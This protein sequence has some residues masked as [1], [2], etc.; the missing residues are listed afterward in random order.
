[1]GKLSDVDATSFRALAVRANYLAQDKP[2]ISLA[3]QKLCMQL[4][5]PNEKLGRYQTGR[6]KGLVYRYDT[7]LSGCAATTQDPP[8]EDVLQSA[9]GW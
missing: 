6:Q 4:A 8:T 9:W 2:D 7:D 3:V 1:M 5:A